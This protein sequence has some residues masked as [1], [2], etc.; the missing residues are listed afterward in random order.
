MWLVLRNAAFQ[1]QGSTVREVLDLWQSIRKRVVVKS[2]AI[3]A[4][5]V[6][7]GPSMG[8]KAQL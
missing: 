5:A 7:D 8:V 6:D 4:V 2:I 1:K 3:R